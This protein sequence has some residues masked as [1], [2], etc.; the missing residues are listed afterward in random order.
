MQQA[1]EQT[2]A[3]H[4]AST[5]QISDIRLQAASQ[6][7]ADGDDRRWWV[8]YK[9][10][11]ARQTQAAKAYVPEG[12]GKASGGSAWGPPGNTSPPAL[13]QRGGANR[14]GMPNPSPEP[15][16]GEYAPKALASNRMWELCAV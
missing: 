7:S 4:P 2:I 6:A 13:Y 10:D 11:C 15:E 3:Q 8:D 5:A 9:K 16:E 1:L 14:N 12:C